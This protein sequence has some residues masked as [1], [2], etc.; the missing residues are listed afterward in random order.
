MAENVAKQLP[1]KLTVKK[2]K[3]TWIAAAAAVAAVIALVFAVNF[4]LHP[5]GADIVYAMEQAFQEVKAYHGIIEII[6]KNAEGK[7][8][9]QAIRE[10]WADKEG[11]YYIKELEGSQAG[12]ITVNNGEKK[13]QQLPK[14]KGLRF[15]CF[16]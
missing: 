16:S 10:V 11:H 2:K 13:W 8:T 4:I 1:K 12:V 15:S 7:E 9:T 5:G 3:H 14:E 6:E